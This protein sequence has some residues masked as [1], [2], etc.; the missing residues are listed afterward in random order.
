MFDRILYAADFDEEWP[1][2]FALLRDLALEQDAE[3][4]V[5]RVVE[6]SEP[7]EGLSK[8]QE[9]DPEERQEIL[10]GEA[11]VDEHIAVRKVTEKLQEAGVFAQALTRQ[12]RIAEEILSVAEEL[13]VDLIVVGGAPHSLLKS[14]LTGHITD[15]I[16]RKTKRPVLLVPRDS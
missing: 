6:L 4:H 1:P 5:L 14:V 2:S 11:Q 9:L 8:K 15:E 7:Q 16:V 3:V 10:T 12:G 13:S